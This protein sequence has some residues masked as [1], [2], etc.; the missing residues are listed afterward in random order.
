MIVWYF[1]LLHTGIINQGY[2]ISFIDFLQ[3]CWRRWVQN[4]L[5]CKIIRLVLIPLCCYVMRVLYSRIASYVEVNCSNISSLKL[6]Y[7]ILIYCP[8][9]YPLYK[10]NVWCMVEECYELCASIS[11]MLSNCNFS[12]WIVMPLNLASLRILASVWFVHEQQILIFSRARWLC[13]LIFSSLPILLPSRDPN[14]RKRL[15]TF[16]SKAEVPWSVVWKHERK[17]TTPESLMK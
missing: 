13:S 14:E 17:H 16:G 10:K 8:H 15:F 2:V 7:G 5:L 1:S 6:L 9:Q 3:F 12:I 11:Q 4:A